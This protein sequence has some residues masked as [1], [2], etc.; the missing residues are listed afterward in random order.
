MHLS[1][2]GE[3]PGAAIRR[4]MTHFARCVV[5]LN[6][7]LFRNYPKSLSSP[8]KQKYNVNKILFL[9][10]KFSEPLEKAFAIYTLIYIIANVSL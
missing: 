4:R 6:N 10:L 9:S 2:T 1:D 8:T 3:L 5:V 7:K